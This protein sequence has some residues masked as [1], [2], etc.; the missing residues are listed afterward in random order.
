MASN[1]LAMASNI[2]QP[3]SAGLQPSS[4]LLLVAMHLVLVQ[5]DAASSLQLHVVLGENVFWTLV[6]P[7]SQIRGTSVSQHLRS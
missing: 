6:N 7:T 1:L 5:E 2:L 4:F 3:T